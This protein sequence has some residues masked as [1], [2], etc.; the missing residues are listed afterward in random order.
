MVCVL[1][2]DEDEFTVILTEEDVDEL[3]W[4]SVALAVNV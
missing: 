2:Q 4:L 1:L 3:F